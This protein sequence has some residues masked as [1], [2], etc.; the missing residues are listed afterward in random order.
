[1]IQSYFRQASD[2]EQDKDSKW[3]KHVIYEGCFL[4]TAKLP[5]HMALT[6][7][8]FQTLW[9][10]Q[11]TE[12]GR[13]VMYGQEIETPR[14]QQAYEK[15][16][17]FSG[18][19]HEPEER[20]PTPTKVKEIQAWLAGI[21]Q[22]QDEEGSPFHGYDFQPNEILINWYQNGHDYIGPHSDDETQLKLVN[23]QC[24]VCTTSHGNTRKFRFRLKTTNEI[25]A[26]FDLADNTICVMGGLTQRLLKHEIVRVQG[27]KGLAIGPRISIT[28]RHF[29]E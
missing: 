2:K 29:K 13:V 5:Q 21:A 26:T 28:Y 14:K 19:T 12:R 20:Y 25:L 6:R 8:D 24:L 7:D 16:Y 27:N 17:Y 11:P 18:M 1:M 15:P 3:K 4:W 10:Q 23:E 9:Q 22:S